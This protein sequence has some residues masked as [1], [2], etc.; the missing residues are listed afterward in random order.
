MD[1][2]HGLG[3]LMLQEKRPDPLKLADGHDVGNPWDRS[4]HAAILFFIK[5][6]GVEFL[7][8]CRWQR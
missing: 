4:S 2:F 6:D 3:G 7:G 8:G 1:E 5:D